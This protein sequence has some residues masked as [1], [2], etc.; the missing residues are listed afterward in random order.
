MSRYPVQVRDAVPD[1]V[2]ALLDIWADVARRTPER[3]AGHSPAEEARNA[4]ARVAAD[5]DERLLVGLVE[6][7]VAGAAHLVRSRVSPL[8]TEMAVY[9]SNLHVLP[10][11][12]R[13]GVGMALIEGAVSWA[14]EKDTMH[15]IT[16]APVHSRDANR[17]LARLGLAQVATI[18]AATVGAL[19]SRLPVETPACARV[20][21]RNQRSV[22]QVLAQRRSLR[23]AQ[24]N[25]GEPTAI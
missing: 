1:D 7:I 8:Q 25:A 19:R 11:Y 22:G 18:R 17:F 3:S 24:R 12:R 2:E 5:P 23:R 4:V 13:R 14:E 16:A 9:V 6:G 21:S 10:G 15:V 20:T